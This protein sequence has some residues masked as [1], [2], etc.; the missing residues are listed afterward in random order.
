[1]KRPPVL[2][3]RWA[4]ALGMVPP[5]LAVAGLTAGAAVSVRVADGR[6]H[7][8]TTAVEPDPPAETTEA[9]NGE[10]GDG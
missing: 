4:A 10:D 5:A 9:D 8:T 3:R 6:I 1:M 7:A 2:P